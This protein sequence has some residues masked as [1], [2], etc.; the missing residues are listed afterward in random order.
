MELEIRLIHEGSS[1]TIFEYCEDSQHSSA[2]FR[3][4]QGHSGGIPIDPELMGYVLIPYNWKEY[5]YHRGCSFS[6][7]SVLENGLISGGKESHKRRQTIIFTPLNPFVGDP[8]E[9]HREDYT[10]PRNV[11]YHRH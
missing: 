8:E 3:A 1:K 11:H 6:I 5:F 4:I 10:V 9:E 7:S 2:Y